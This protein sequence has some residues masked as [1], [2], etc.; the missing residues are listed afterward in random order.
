M[1]P[2][3]LFFD[4][5]CNL[6]NGTVDFLIRRDRR[7]GLRFASL[8]SRAAHARL[9]E[10][11][12]RM[13]SLSSVVLM[14]PDGRL[15]KESDAVLMALA[16]LGLGWKIL[17]TLLRGVP[18]SVRDGLYRWV[19]RNRYRWFGKHASCRLPSPQER[20]RFLPDSEPMLDSSP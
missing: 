6:C 16:K 8:Q 18:R 20:E 17:G 13:H 9:G 7:G 19:A 4:G 10:N 2:A 11:V 12:L 3:V 5:V 15:F 1:E 14:E